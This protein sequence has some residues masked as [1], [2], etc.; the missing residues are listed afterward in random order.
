M[1]TLHK[2]PDFWKARMV[3]GFAVPAVTAAVIVLIFLIILIFKHNPEARICTAWFVD[4]P[5]E[6]TL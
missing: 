4:T 2:Y 6:E 1:D 5:L 3:A